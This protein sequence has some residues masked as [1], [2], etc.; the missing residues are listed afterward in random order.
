MAPRKD[1]IL[2]PQLNLQCLEEWS[3]TEQEQAMELLLRMETSC[4]PAVIWT[5]AKHP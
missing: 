3:E 4:L 1:L 2:Q 5:W